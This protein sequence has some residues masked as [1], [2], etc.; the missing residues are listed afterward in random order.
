MLRLDTQILTLDN[1]PIQATGI[2]AFVLSNN[3][4]YID[5]C[6]TICPDVMVKLVLQR[7]ICTQ[8]IVEVKPT[9]IG[10]HKSGCNAKSRF[11]RDY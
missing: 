10:S 7:I 4:G 2:Q 11:D 8:W 6:Q 3:D 1:A 9:D 5:C